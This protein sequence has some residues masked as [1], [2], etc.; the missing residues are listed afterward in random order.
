VQEE[1]RDLHLDRRQFQHLMGAI[2]RRSRYHQ[3]LHE[4]D[5]GRTTWTSVGA[6][7]LGPEPRWPFFP[8]RWPEDWR[9]LRG[10]NGESDEG[11]LLE[12]D[13]V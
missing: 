6:S 13:D 2:R 12:V 11:G 4:Q 3:G 10:L 5:G 8:P 9:G 7:S 1:R